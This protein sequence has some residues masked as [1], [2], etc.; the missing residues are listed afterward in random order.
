LAGF[1]Q[2]LDTPMV[3]SHLMLSAMKNALEIRRNNDPEK[4]ARRP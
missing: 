1:F 3:D 4:S 2:R